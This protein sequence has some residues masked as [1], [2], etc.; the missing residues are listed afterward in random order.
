MRALGTIRRIAQLGTTTTH[1]SSPM[2]SR[3]P[4]CSATLSPAVVHN[5]SEQRFVL[6]IDGHEA[7]LLYRLKGTTMHLDHTGVPKELEGRGLGKILAKVCLTLFL[8]SHPY[9]Y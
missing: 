8:F 5:Q 3:Q 7:E 2:S 1:S 6:P 9:I 4:F